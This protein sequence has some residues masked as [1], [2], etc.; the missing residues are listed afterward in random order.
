MTVLPLI[1]IAVTV[2]VAIYKQLWIFPLAFIA[3]L[4]LDA[5]AV[6]PLGSASIFFV[7]W[8]FLILLYERKYEIN[9]YLFIISSSFFGSWLFLSIFQYDNT[10][11]QSGISSIIALTVFLLLKKSQRKTKKQ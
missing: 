8:I 1:L 5:T 3:G 7:C 6:R 2:M 9:S 10:L 4:I 11:I